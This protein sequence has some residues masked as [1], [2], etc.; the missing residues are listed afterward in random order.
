[1][2]EMKTNDSIKGWKIEVESKA[3]KAAAEAEGKPYAP[4]TEL[5]AEYAEGE[6]SAPGLGN[7]E[8]VLATADGLLLQVHLQEMN[9]I[10]LRILSIFRKLR[11]TL[12]NS[13]DENTLVYIGTRKKPIN[14]PING[15]IPYIDISLKN[16]FTLWGLNQLSLWRFRFENSFI[17]WQLL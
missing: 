7:R 2:Q 15:N 9:T 5:F 16:L 4:M 12:T 17:S 1:M 10:L 6:F 3:A 13:E 8:L 14:L 11:S